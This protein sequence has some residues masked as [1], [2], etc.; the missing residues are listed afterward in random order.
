MKSRCRHTWKRIGQYRVCTNCNGR[1]KVGR[2]RLAQEKADAK[3]E[4]QQA[5]DDVQ[6]RIAFALERIANEV[7]MMRRGLEYSYRKPFDIFVEMA[8]EEE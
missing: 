6:V 3:K 2:Q 5:R 4:A 8:G 7:Q 1:M